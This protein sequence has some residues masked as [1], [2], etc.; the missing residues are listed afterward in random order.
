MRTWEKGEIHLK[1]RDS[2]LG[3]AKCV[4]THFNQ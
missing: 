4:N 3:A 2:P 1:D